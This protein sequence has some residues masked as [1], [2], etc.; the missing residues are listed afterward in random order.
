[1]NVSET[2]STNSGDDGEREPP[3]LIPNTEVK[4]FR[5]EST[6]LETTWEDRAL[7]DF[8]KSEPR[9]ETAEHIY[10]KAERGNGEPIPEPNPSGT[11]TQHIP[12]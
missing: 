2:Y 8:F 11:Q 3:V 6:W 1:M 5:A 7:P 10:R 4:P 12:P 9:S